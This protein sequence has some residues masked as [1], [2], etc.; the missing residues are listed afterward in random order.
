MSNLLIT[1]IGM[2]NKAIYQFISKD[3]YADNNL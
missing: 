2:K 1:M 3:L